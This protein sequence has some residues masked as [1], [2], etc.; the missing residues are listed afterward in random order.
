M[1]TRRVQPRTRGGD[2]AW[3][4]RDGGALR[5]VAHGPVPRQRRALV[6][7]VNPRQP[8]AKAE[9]P[10]PR[11]RTPTARCG[12][13]RD[14]RTQPLQAGRTRDAASACTAGKRR[15]QAW[16]TA[17]HRAPRRRRRRR[18]MGGRRSARRPSN[19]PGEVAAGVA[20]AVDAAGTPARG[21]QRTV[22]SMAPSMACRR[23]ATAPLPPPAARPQHVAA[24]AAA[25]VP[26]A[27]GVAAAGGLLMMVSAIRPHRART[28]HCHCTRQQ[29][30]LPPPRRL[31][32]CST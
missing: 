4:A 2:G 32:V 9:P 7:R 11:P 10:A 31:Y 24:L 27:S 29:P 14:A 23:T 21:G 15:R 30:P 18:A 5:R 12:H 8:L 16:L 28:A 6:A 26:A 22:P 20:D 25:A 17:G 3:D 1:S 13:T 19:R